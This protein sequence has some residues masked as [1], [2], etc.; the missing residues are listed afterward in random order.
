MTAP[1]QDIR[2]VLRKIR[3]IEIKVRHLVDQAFAGSYHSVFRGQGMDF[4]EVRQ[5]QPG[6]EIRSI[7]WNV[8]ARFGDP[9]VKQFTEERELSVVLLV[10][11][12]GSGNFGSQER[13]KRETAAEIAA[14]LAFSATR[15]NDR[16]GLLL[17]SDR[18][19]LYIPP[20]KGRS[21]VLR[22]IREVLFFRPEGRGTDLAGAL[23]YVNRVMHR[24]AILFL[25]SDFFSPDFQKE[26]S[27]TSR[28]HDVIAVQIRDPLEEELPR[29]G[30]ILLEDEETGAQLEVNTSDEKVRRRFREETEAAQASLEKT[31]GRCG[32]DR[33]ALTTAGE[34]LPLLR[35]FFQRRLRRIRRS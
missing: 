23:R 9:H 26:L 14:T 24:R 5:Y 6:D 18:V 20:R 30:R 16:V 22:V 28:R 33:V 29:V 1:D 2:S 7:D 32:V 11:L 21:H 12:S 3:A 15:N 35:S 8:T 10:D 19:E 31:L 25:L 27:L 17:F 4:E 34:Y 13:S